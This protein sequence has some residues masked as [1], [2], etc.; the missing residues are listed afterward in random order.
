MPRKLFSKILLGTSLQNALLFSL[1]AL[2]MRKDG[3]SKDSLFPAFA[4]GTSNNSSL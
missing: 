3:Q 1:L 2:I 4:T